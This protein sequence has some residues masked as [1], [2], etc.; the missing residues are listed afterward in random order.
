MSVK[1]PLG[2][3][4]ICKL[5]LLSDSRLTHI[6][7][8]SAT[9]NLWLVTADFDHWLRFCDTGDDRLKPKVAGDWNWSTL[10]IKWHVSL[11]LPVYIHFPYIFSGWQLPSLIHTA[12]YCQKLLRKKSTSF[13]TCLKTSNRNLRKLL[14]FWG[15]TLWLL[16]LVTGYVSL[17][18]NH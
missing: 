15:E 5:G 16:S 8:A 12:R 14:V 6:N 4:K 9:G 11:Y 17:V 3:T 7:C 1:L 10:L 18:G 13:P 2:E